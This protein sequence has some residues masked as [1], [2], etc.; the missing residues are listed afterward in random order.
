MWVGCKSTVEITV[1]G[2]EHSSGVGE[3]RGS[4]DGVDRL[5][6]SVVDWC[7][8]FSLACSLR[9]TTSHVD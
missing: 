8:F 9:A 5:C 7:G 2:G 3:A 4:R 1:A 6:V